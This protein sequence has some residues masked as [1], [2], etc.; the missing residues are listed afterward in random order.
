MTSPEQLNPS[1]MDRR[2]CHVG[3]TLAGTERVESLQVR[4]AISMKGASSQK[5]PSR[6]N[7]ALITKKAY[8]SLYI[9]FVKEKILKRDHYNKKK[10]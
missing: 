1:W 3:R 6:D 8:C 9:F 2:G 4:S 10:V 7:M 5:F